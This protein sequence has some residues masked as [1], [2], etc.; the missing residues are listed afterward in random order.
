MASAAA[1]SS[2]E[3]ATSSG[4]MQSSRK[5]VSIPTCGEVIRSKTIGIC[6]EDAQPRERVASAELDRM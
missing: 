6:N 1:P 4:T 3:G 5:R 2:P